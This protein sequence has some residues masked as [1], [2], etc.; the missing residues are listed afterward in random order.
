MK[1]RSVIKRMRKVVKGKAWFDD[2]PFS[3][4]TY[5][6]L[7]WFQFKCEPRF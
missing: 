5:E 3:K 7:G 6:H 2:L 4:Y 1:N